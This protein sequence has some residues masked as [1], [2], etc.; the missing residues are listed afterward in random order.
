MDQSD[1]Q[2]PLIEQTSPRAVFAQLVAVAL[3]QIPVR[4][5][6][7]A[8]AYLIELLDQQVA[9]A[10]EPD[11][12]QALAE[13]LLAARLEAGTD[14]I[15][16]MRGVGDR[17]LFGAGYFGDS[18]ARRAID[19]DYFREIGRHAY[20]DVAARLAGQGVG[21]TWTRLYRELSTHFA[22]F[23]DVLAEV[24]DR[25]RRSP[26]A[27]ML[28]LY[29]RFLRTGSARDRER[30]ARAGHPLPDRAGLRWWQ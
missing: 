11:S 20:E 9:R 13:T 29:E 5:S 19:L 25:S 27:D 15:R 21:Q 18:L 7:M 8:T 6:P 4:P 22:E 1:G 17:A 14:R 24:A 28:R 2:R 30:L 3:A 16:R 23:V 12:D 26:P 10:A